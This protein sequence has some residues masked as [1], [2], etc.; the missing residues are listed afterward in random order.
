MRAVLSA[1]ALIM[2]A[3]P[4]LAQP[5]ARFVPESGQSRCDAS[6]WHDDGRATYAEAR[7]E[8]LPQAS[9][10]KIHAGPN[11]AI[12]I[13]GANRSDVLVHACIH[14]SAS[15]E[16]EA[17]SLA[18]RVKITQGAGN[19]VPDGP[20]HEHG[21]SWSVSY[22]VWLPNA[23]NLDAATVNGSVRIEDVQGTIE[24][25]TVN[26]GM[27]LVRLGGDVDSSTVNGGVKVELTGTTWQGPGLRVK[28][29]NGG[30]H[31]TVPASYSANVETSTV[32]GGIHC[33]FPITV[34]GKLEKHVSFQ[35]GGGGAE[36]HSSTVNGGIHFEKGA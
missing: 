11:G 8:T 15:T 29:T 26:G 36:I 19:I 12:L 3:L 35:L 28:T 2:S 25:K 7:Q 16:D 24:A 23:S 4:L 5:G 10:D 30:I 33:D 9:L 13:H 1:A 6:S 31:F 18:S 34:Q 27:N 14:A 20:Q 32:N 17:R 22:E 21:E